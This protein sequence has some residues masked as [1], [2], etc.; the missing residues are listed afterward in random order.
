MR[1]RRHEFPTRLFISY[2]PTEARK[3]PIQLIRNI[4]KK[5]EEEDKRKGK[6]REGKGRSNGNYRVGQPL[7]CNVQYV[8]CRA[9]PR[10]MSLFTGYC[11]VER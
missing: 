1:K 11:A 6:G 4:I 10:L 3:Y 7:Q 5:E 9:A 2:L 8:S